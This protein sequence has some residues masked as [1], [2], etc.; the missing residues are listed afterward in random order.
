MKPLI[1]VISECH[2]ENLGDQAIARSICEILLPYYRVSK[3][4][5][6]RTTPSSTGSFGTTGTTGTAVRN[7]K[8]LRL[9]RA[10]PPITKAR[11]RWHVLHEKAKFARHFGS[12]IERSDLVILGGGQLI[13]NNVDLFCEKLGLVSKQSASR[14]VPFALVGVG[15]DRKMEKKNWRII[16]NAVDGANFIILRDEMSRERVDAAL[17][18]VGDLAVLPDL[19]FALTNPN[20]NR[21]VNNRGIALAVNVMDL[22]CMLQPSN[23]LGERDIEKLFGIFC[24]VVE[25]ARKNKATITLFTSGTADDLGAANEVRS[26][27]YSQI[28]I[29][30]PIFHPRTL[31]ELLS[32]LA[33][34]REVV[35]TRMH[36]GILAYISGCNTLCINW[37]DKVHGVWSTVG[38][39]ERVIQMEEIAHHD[40]GEKIIE[41]FQKL[42]PASLDYLDELAEKVRRGVLDPI[43]KALTHPQGNGT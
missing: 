6:N 36:A 37:D 16:E 24:D 35:A 39:H 20:R 7:L 29:D 31:D 22:T 2:S 33:N 1:S 34:V 13:K 17:N 40:A 28:G 18:Y 42:T 38:Q 25:A 41:R 43:G 26:R 23:S 11:F 32:F 5:F 27:V 12:A 3:T 4:S 15:V 14:S 8:V 9:F 19:A 21:T 10:V 30:L